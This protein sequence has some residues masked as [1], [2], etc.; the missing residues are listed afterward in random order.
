MWARI[1]CILRGHAW[2]ALDEVRIHCDRT[3][4]S[5]RLVVDRCWN[6]KEE[7]LRLRLAKDY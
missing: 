4:R 1:F 3:G 2:Y 5:P 7:R 6:C